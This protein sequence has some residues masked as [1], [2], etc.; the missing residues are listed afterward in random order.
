MP[1]F[2]PLIPCPACGGEHLFLAELARCA[3][4]AEAERDELQEEA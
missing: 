1:D 4:A 2:I 3:D